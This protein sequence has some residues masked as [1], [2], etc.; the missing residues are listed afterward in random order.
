MTVTT[1]RNGQPTE[2]RRAHRFSADESGLIPGGEIDKE[3]DNVS[4]SINEIRARLALIQLDDGTLVAIDDVTK[5][6]ATVIEQIRQLY[7][8]DSSTSKE[9]AQ[10]AIEAAD[11]LLAINKNFESALNEVRGLAEASKISTEKGLEAVTEIKKIRREVL[12]LCGPIQEAANAAIEFSKKASFSF[13]TF[14]SCRENESIPFSNLS[15]SS[16]VKVGDH[17]LSLD[18]YDLFQIVNM[19]DLYATL[20]AKVG[21]LRGPRG[22]RGEQ[23][24]SAPRGERGERGPM[25][26]SPFATCFGNFNVS[27]DGNLQLEVVGLSPAEFEINEN[28]RLEAKI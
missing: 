11:Q 10:K 24:E 25:G 18:T 19:G 6:S 13:R 23:G 22:F 27:A 20:G 1:P 21:N 5:L 4:R 12:D 9:Y 7:A 2:Y 14:P 8:N 16:G 28:G 26:Q 3:L 15:P 17:V